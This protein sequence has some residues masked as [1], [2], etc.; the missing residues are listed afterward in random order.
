MG[1]GNNIRSIAQF[2]GKDLHIH[3]GQK[4]ARRK[5]THGR[6]FFSPK[7][8][9]SCDPLLTP[10]HMQL[11]ISKPSEVTKDTCIVEIGL[12]W[13]KAYDTWKALGPVSSFL[14]QEHHC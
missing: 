3:S 8:C 6:F 9:F 4:F 5:K 2:N 7:R 11:C 14:Y 13:Q 1:V 12:Y 10:N